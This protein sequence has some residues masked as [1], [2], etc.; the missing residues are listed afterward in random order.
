MVTYLT[1]FTILGE[2]LMVSIIRPHLLTLLVSSL[3]V[4][5][6]QSLIAKKHSQK[7]QP[8]QQEQQATRKFNTEEELTEAM[9][10]ST[11]DEIPDL[12]DLAQ[13]VWTQ[14]TTQLQPDQPDQTFQNLE[15]SFVEA[16]VQCVAQGCGLLADEDSAL[17]EQTFLEMAQQ[18][19][20]NFAPFKE[21]VLRQCSYL[22]A[23]KRELA[24]HSRVILKL[25]S[26]SCDCDIDKSFRRI[27]RS[28]ITSD[29]H[30]IQVNAHNFFYPGIPPVTMPMLLYFKNGEIV[31]W[32]GYKDQAQLQEAITALFN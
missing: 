29:I 16:Y 27:T 26:E 20:I 1:N 24:K 13:N 31:G 32:S 10:P 14:I 30:L 21:T 7:S 6:P 9:T 5:T 2:C 11:Q 25:Y 22:F 8:Q 12:A 23:L 28:P 4:T 15:N 19:I 17:A 3:L 18:K